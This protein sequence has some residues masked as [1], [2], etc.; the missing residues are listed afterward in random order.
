[1]ERGKMDT[2]KLYDDFIKEEK[3]LINWKN[4]PCDI[5]ASF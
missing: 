5:N 3:K 4:I 1:M 2:Q